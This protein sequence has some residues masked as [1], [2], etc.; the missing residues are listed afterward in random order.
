MSQNSLYRKR[1]E[2]NNEN[3]DLEESASNLESSV[4]LEIL[5][6]NYSGNLDFM[7]SELKINNS[8]FEK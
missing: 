3:K 7:V 4:T 6:M 8:K 2:K 1:K 5:P